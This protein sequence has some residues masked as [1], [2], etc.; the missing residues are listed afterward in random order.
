MNGAHSVVV[1]TGCRARGDE[2]G[3]PLAPEVCPLYVC[4]KTRLIFK[5][6]TKTLGLKPT[7][8]HPIDTSRGKGKHNCCNYDKFNLLQSNIKREGSSYIINTKNQ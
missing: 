2:R 1:G 4:L 8:S 5:D 3:F 6:V 7:T